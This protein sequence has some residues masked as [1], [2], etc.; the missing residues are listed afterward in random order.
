MPVTEQPVRFKASDGKEFDSREEAERHDALVVATKNYDAVK[1]EM[2]RALARTV[3]TADGHL[4]EFATWRYYYVWNGWSGVDVREVSIGHPGIT[5]DDQGDVLLQV[6]NYQ[7]P[8]H[9]VSEYRI[10]HLYKD[11]RA[12]KQEQLR[13]WEE[14]LSAQQEDIDELRKEFNPELASYAIAPEAKE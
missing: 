11:K 3:K 7:N 4:F 13:L 8:K 12:A 14:R 6:T 5:I 10:D 1:N 2:E 9:E